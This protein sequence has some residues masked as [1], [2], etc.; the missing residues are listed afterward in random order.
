MD[1]EEVRTKDLRSLHRSF[2]RVSAQQAN[3][4]SKRLHKSDLGLDTRTRTIR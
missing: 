4:Q 3:L 2:E 1:E